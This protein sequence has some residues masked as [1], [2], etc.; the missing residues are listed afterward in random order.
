MYLIGGI[1]YLHCKVIGKIATAIADDFEMSLRHVGPSTRV[2]DYRSLWMLLSR[3]T[4]DAGNGYCY[5]MTFISLYLFLTI[6]LTIYGLLSQLQEGFGIKDVGLTIT[7]VFSVALLFFV[8]DEAH[9]ASNC[10]SICFS[11]NKNILH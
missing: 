3:I 1:W 2:A 11:I 8:C 10:V 4:R 6:T 9:Y 7:A 5:S